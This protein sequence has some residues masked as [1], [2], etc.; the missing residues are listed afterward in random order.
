MLEGSCPLYI[1]LLEKV[2]QNVTSELTGGKNIKAIRQE[3][4]PGVFKKKTKDQWSRKTASKVAEKEWINN[5]D[6]PK[7]YSMHV[8]LRSNGKSQ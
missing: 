8:I 4:K 6:A 7:L 2:T 1:K 3:G 5:A